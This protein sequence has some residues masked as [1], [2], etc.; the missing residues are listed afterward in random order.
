MSHRVR[1]LVCASLAVLAILPTGLSPASAAFPGTN[2]MIVFTKYLTSSNGEIYIMRN[3]GS[4]ATRLTQNLVTDR[5]PSLSPDGL[6]IVFSSK[7]DGNEEIYSMAVNGSDVKRLTTRPGTDY[8]PSW[9]PDGSRIVYTSEGTV[10]VMN[11]DGSNRTELTEGFHPAWSPDGSKIAFARD[12]FSSVFTMTSTGQAITQISP[13]GI[14]MFSEPAWSPDG[15]EIVAVREQSDD[16]TLVVLSGSGSGVVRTLSTDE[17]QFAPA[18]SP[19]GDEILFASGD[20]FVMDANGGEP[21]NL[22]RDS[23]RDDYPDWGVCPSG[24]TCGDVTPPSISDLSAS[25]SPFSPNDDGRADTTRITFDLSEDSTVL[26]KFQDDRRRDVFALDT[27]VL[28]AGSYSFI[29]DGADFAGDV[30]PSGDFDIIVSA[31]DAAGNSASASSPVVIDNSFVI[32]NKG[33]GT[34]R[35]GSSSMA[36]AKELL[37]DP[38]SRERIRACFTGYDLKWGKSLSL[39]FKGTDSPRALAAAVYTPTLPTSSGQ[40]EVA[41]TSR[42]LQVGDS[43]SR[44]V[45]LYPNARK[46]SFQGTVWYLIEGSR[47]AGFVYVKLGS[48]GTVKILSTG[49]SC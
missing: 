31:T 22:T 46:K 34:L 17:L 35:F 21:R 24:Q 42:G 15:Q 9:S 23:Y 5:M 48:T 25:P 8:D 7:R 30:L 45:T 18:W 2:G 6:R 36:A 32:S 43:R 12:D 41:R 19:D 47:S 27:Q 49:Y 44:M 29:W 38:T 16:E 3:D 28:E 33:L 1:M 14:R 39:L 13:S 37:G 10:T 26:V 4:D 11:A 20:I 40:R